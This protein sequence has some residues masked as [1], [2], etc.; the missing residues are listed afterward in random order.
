MLHS[1][2]VESEVARLGAL[3]DSALTWLLLTGP[4]SRNLGAGAKLPGAALN[5]NVV[6]HMAAESERLAD[7]QR[8]SLAC[9]QSGQAIYSRSM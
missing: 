8:L 9:V 2:G 1:E 7:S 4:G 6:G 5:F 3:R